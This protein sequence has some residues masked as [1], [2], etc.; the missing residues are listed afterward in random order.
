[1]QHDELSPN[2]WQNQTTDY[3]PDTP[4]PAKIRYF[5]GDNDDYRKYQRLCRGQQVQVGLRKS[6]PVCAC[7]GCFS[8]VAASVAA[9]A[10][11]AIASLQS[12][13]CMLFKVE[14]WLRL[15]LQPD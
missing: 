13:F 14:R 11:A 10:V 3:Q 5:D 15:V 7:S 12:V 6:S 4:I 1:M 9:V 8:V 2:Y